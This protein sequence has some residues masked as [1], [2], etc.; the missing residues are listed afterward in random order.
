VRGPVER[1][2]P[3]TACSRCGRSLRARPM[4]QHGLYPSARPG[5][6]DDFFHDR[7]RGSPPAGRPPVTAP[8]RPLRPAPSRRLRSRVPVEQLI[9]AACI[10]LAGLAAPR[11][12]ASRVRRSR[13][14]SSGPFPSRRPSAGF[15]GSSV[16]GL[17]LVPARITGRPRQAGCRLSRCIV[18][19]S[20]GTRARLVPRAV[21]QTPIR[22]P[23]PR[24]FRSR[25]SASPSDHPAPAASAVPLPAARV[26]RSA[27]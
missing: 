1:P 27:G 15:S 25:T 9:P 19:S 22:T 21:S 5:L 11:Q 4:G 17:D 24:R 16:L 18:A 12:S 2:G 10:K 23:R 26:R 14:V 7:P 8:R 3:G 13:D 6:V 20:T